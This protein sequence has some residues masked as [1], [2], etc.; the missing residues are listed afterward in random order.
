MARCSK[1][2]YEGGSAFCPMCGGQMSLVCPRCGSMLA[3]GF[4]FCATCGTSLDVPPVTGQGTN[5]GRLSIGDVGMVRGSIDA[6]THITSNVGSQT[7]FSGPVGDIHVHQVP[8]QPTAH[9]LLQE[10]VNSMQARMYNAALECFQ[11]ALRKG[12]STP[13]LHFYMA[14]ALLGGTRPKLLSLNTI[15]GIED[16]L[17][18]AIQNEPRC[19]HARVLWALVKQDYYVMNGMFDRSPTVSDLLGQCG[20]IAQQHLHEMITLISAPGN[21]VW[22]LLCSLHQG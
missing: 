11:A 7:N 12:L 6:S 8:S 10:G 18:V 19:D 1:C 21:R 14:L 4:R 9:D 5:P 22:E 16:Y 2:G 17:R 20:P 3:S 13:D 15:R